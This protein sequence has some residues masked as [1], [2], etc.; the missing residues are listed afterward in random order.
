MGG[1]FDFPTGQR[2]CHGLKL[3]QNLGVLFGRG[4]TQGGMQRTTPPFGGT[5]AP[6]DGEFRQEILTAGSDGNC[7]G[8]VVRMTW[9]REG[10][11]G[12]HEKNNDSGR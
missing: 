4:D 9:G 3:L 2:T 7:L 6:A 12:V 1:A 11:C 5:P 8:T 10:F